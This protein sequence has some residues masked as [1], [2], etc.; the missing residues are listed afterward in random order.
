[1][2]THKLYIAHKKQ[3]L[4][5]NSSAS[6]RIEIEVLIGQQ[7]KALKKQDQFLS[8]STH[9]HAHPPTINKYNTP[10]KINTNTKTTIE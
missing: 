9:P 3:T 5:L 8:A 2:G 6:E 7:H 10:K 1:L 4:L